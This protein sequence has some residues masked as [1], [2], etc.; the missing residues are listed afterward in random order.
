MRARRSESVRRATRLLNPGESAKLLSRS[1]GLAQLVDAQTHCTGALLRGMFRRAA[2]LGGVRARAARSCDRAAAPGRRG[3]LRP[4]PRLLRPALG[5]RR[6]VRRQGR[7]RLVRRHA[8]TP[9]AA[10]S[11]S[12][13]R[14]RR[15]ASTCCSA[16]PR[17]SWP[18]AA[19][20]RS[21]SPRQP[22]PSGDW[23]VSPSGGAFRLASAA[24]RPLARRR[25]RRAA[26]TTVDGAGA[27]FTFEKAA[28][29]A[30]FPEAEINISGE[31]DARRGDA[32]ARCAAWPTCTCTGWPSSSSAAGRTAASR[33]ART[34]S[35]SRSSTAPTT[36]PTARA[37][38]LENAVSK[39]EPL[40]HD[41]VGLAGVQG[42]ADVRL[43]HPRADVLQVGRARVA[44]RP[45][46][47]REPARRE[48]G[49]LR[50]LS[51]QAEQ[52]QRDGRGAAA[53]QAHPRARGVRRRAERRPGQGL[54]ADRQ[55]PVRGARGHQRRQARGDPRH[56]GLPAVRL[57]ADRRPAD[58]RRG[59]DRAPAQRGLRPRRARHGARQ[60][61]R[62]RAGRRR[63]RQRLDRRRRQQRQQGRDRLVLGHGDLQGPAGRVRP[64][65]AHAVRPQPRRPHRQRP[66]GVHPVGHHAG[67]RPRA[68]LQ[69]ARA[70]RRSATSR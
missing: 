6:Q 43:A 69:Q 34:A 37:R 7:R 46:R 23:K 54:A 4:R 70:L 13:C 3:R 48:Q 14:P 55:R 49:P 56:R 59:A 51:A 61:V 15:S 16:R 10:R 45:A 62:Q 65:A 17:T 47:L 64:R 52:L 50:G 29:C 42:L 11:R 22:G 66:G 68:A 63:G 32:S 24:Q 2:I 8:R 21:R 33:G 57:P 40:T 27:R 28:G 31:P 36:S 38:S 18:P 35:P 53:G 44:R 12:A 58:V 41:T 1:R 26:L 60:Q 20:T 30:T 39:D 19:A 67:L 5:G 25:R 9:S